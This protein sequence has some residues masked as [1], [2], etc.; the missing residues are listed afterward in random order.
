MILKKD[1]NNTVKDSKEITKPPSN[2]IANALANKRALI[3]S[4][5]LKSSKPN[6]SSNNFI[7][8]SNTNNASTNNFKP[9]S[10]S[11]L[12]GGVKS[13]F[14]L[15]DNLGKSLNTNIEGNEVNSNFK[16]TGRAIETI[17]IKKLLNGK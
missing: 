10:T 3:S 16:L 17:T 5:N 11:V 15:P 13:S 2:T 12:L 7:G 9:F 8:S 1:P 4:P 6:G 14:K